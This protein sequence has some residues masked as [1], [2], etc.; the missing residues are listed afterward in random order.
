MAV[1]VIGDGRTRVVRRDPRHGQARRRCGR[2]RRRGRLAR[3]LGVHVRHRH[4]DR[5]RRGLHP[6]PRAAGRLHLDHVG[7]VAAL[8]LRV[9]EVGR[10]VERQIPG[11]RPDREETP[12]RPA[13]DQVAL[14]VVIVV[15]RQH[16]ASHR[17]VLRRVERRRCAERRCLV[18]GRRATARVRPHA[19]ALGVRGPHLHLIRRVLRKARE[20]RRGGRAVVVPVRP[21]AARA[22]P[23]LHVVVRDGRAPVVRRRPHD[24]QACY[25]RG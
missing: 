25:R 10:I 14:D 5:L 16:R 24:R 9:L 18:G 11:A 3:R 15:R 17:L 4:C 12:V 8:V 22:R 20:R 19:G 23:V 21:V 13:G 2:H 7:V 1:V 6:L